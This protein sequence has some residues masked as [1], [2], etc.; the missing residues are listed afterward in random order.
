[1]N[2]ELKRIIRYGPE[3]VLSSIRRLEEGLSMSYEVLAISAVS[4]ETHLCTENQ[5]LLSRGRLGYIGSGV[6]AYV[7]VNL[8][9][10]SS[11]EEG[12]SSQC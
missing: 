9:S 12:A 2:V 10:V 1:M 7:L 8:P 11:R 4:I 6:D 5:G 3:V